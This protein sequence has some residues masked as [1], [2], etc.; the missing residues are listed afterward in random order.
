MRLVRDPRT[1]IDTQ[2]TRPDH[3]R[4]AAF[5][6]RAEVY[7]TPSVAEAATSSA[8]VCTTVVPVL[9][10]APGTGKTPGGAGTGEL[11]SHVR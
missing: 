2:D 9:G 6:A 4:T 7:Y 1:T 11:K 8:N 3:D 5:T 10:L